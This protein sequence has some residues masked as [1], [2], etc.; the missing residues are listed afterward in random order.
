MPD[1]SALVIVYEANNKTRRPLWVSS[2]LH[3]D[4]YP[5]DTLSLSCAIRCKCEHAHASNV[6]WH[7]FVARPKR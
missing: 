6:S 2:G 5:A 3:C 1:G 7:T 4:S